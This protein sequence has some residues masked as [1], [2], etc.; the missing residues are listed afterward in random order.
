MKKLSIYLKNCYGIKCFK[1]EFVFYD[2]DDKDPHRHVAIYAS[3]GTMK[4]SLA[5]TFN[6]I[7]NN[8]KPKEL[9]YNRTSEYEIKDEEGKSVK[10]DQILVIGSYQDN[11]PVLNITSSS[12]S[13][14][15]N[16]KLKKKYDSITHEITEKEKNVMKKLKSSSGANNVE[17]TIIEDFDCDKHD[18]KAIF[19][20]LKK[21][22]K[23]T[24]DY[25]LNI[26]YDTIFN[27]KVQDALKEDTIKNSLKKYIEQYKKLLDD[28]YYF[29][30]EFDL[31]NANTVKNNLVKNGFFS[32][33]HQVLFKSKIGK[34][35]IIHNSVEFEA[36][37]NEEKNKID[38]KTKEIWNDI[39]KILIKTKELRIFYK[40]L[41]DNPLLITKIFDND[42]KK[43]FWMSHFELHQLSIK[44]FLNFYEEQ[45]RPLEEIVAKAND[46]QTSWDDV[47]ELF[48]KRFNVPFEISIKNKP[49]AILN[50]DVP[51]LE[52]IF[53]EGSEEEKIND[54]AKMNFL[55]TGE[56]RSF[57]L[58]NVLFKIEERKKNNKE[59]L[60]VI[61]DIADSFDYKNKYA[62]IQYLKEIS[63]N[64]L[65][66]LLIMTHNFDFFRI[67]HRTIVKEHRNCY[68]AT[69][70]DGIQL[71]MADCINRDPFFNFRN[72]LNTPI[73]LIVAITFMRNIVEYTLGKQDKS[74]I[75]L[76]SMLHW[77]QETSDTTV[78]ELIDIINKVLPTNGLSTQDT[79]KDLENGSVKILNLIYDEADKILN[80]KC[81]E[82]DKILNEKCDEAD[83]FLKSCEQS[84]LNSKIVLAIAIRLKTEHFIKQNINENDC[85]FKKRKHISTS[86]LIECYKKQFKNRKK[87]IEIL[88][89]VGLMTPE[90]I[91]LNSFMYEPIIDMDDNELKELYKVV[92]ELNPCNNGNIDIKT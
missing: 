41:T 28:S 40:C 81:D 9:V 87:E 25:F 53:K 14:L 68:F 71:T 52:Y 10:G 32:A 83:K 33:E 1:N 55:C 5:K 51:V 64:N 7:S 34:D 18:L 91:H 65:F 67:I 62:I 13:I 50:G 4:S 29:K 75:T 35:K 36:A 16:E 30:N 61:D 89:R 11:N 73:K 72:K 76:S 85:E 38:K 69:K 80:E 79:I 26:K 59:T 84:R 88:D 20:L 37:I 22:S 42:I 24:A 12:I 56:E 45:E 90:I 60:L 66:H 46:E 77:R 23:D 19:K 43:K 74:Y 2:D 47:L 92:L 31:Y 21:E 57:Y 8:E 63:Q 44:E 49:S 3:N 48:K 6:D 82:A 78:K 58:L 39:H 17:D 86:Y 54:I 27:K 15:V 70:K